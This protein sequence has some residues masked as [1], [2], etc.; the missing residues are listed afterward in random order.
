MRSQC[1]CVVLCSDYSVFT[2]EP[3]E[4]EADDASTDSVDQKLLIFQDGKP[5]TVSGHAL[6]RQQF[7]SVAW[8][9]MLNMRRERKAFIYTWASRSAQLESN[10]LLRVLKPAPLLLQADHVPVVR[11]YAPPPVA[12][13]GKHPNQRPQPPVSAHLPAEEEW[14]TAQIRHQPAGPEFLRSGL[15]IICPSPLK[16]ERL[17]DLQLL[18]WQKPTIQLQI[19]SSKRIAPINIQVIWFSYPY[20]QDLLRMLT[21]NW[22][23]INC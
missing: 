13:H 20:K 16:V 21:N 4:E 7:S 10:W 1:V 12:G 8:L 23:S 11:C 15:I 18:Y 22:L 17:S 3:A 9:H 14:G 6:W 2:Q 5:G 19:H